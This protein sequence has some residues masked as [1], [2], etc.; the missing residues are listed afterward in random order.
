MTRRLPAAFAIGVRRPVHAGD[1]RPRERTTWRCELHD[2]ADPSLL[3]RRAAD[4]ADARSAASASRP[5]YT[6]DPDAAGR[7]D[8]RAGGCARPLALGTVR[9]A[10]AARHRRA[11]AASIPTSRRSRAT[12][13]SP[14]IAACRRS[15]SRP[16]S[17]AAQGTDFKQLSEYRVGDSVRHIDW[18]AT[19]RHGQADRPRVPGRARPVRH[20]ARRLRPAHARRRSAGRDRHDALRPGAERRDAAVVRRAQAGRRGRRDDVRHASRRGALVRAAQGR[21]GAERADGRSCTASSRRRRIP[22]TSPRRR[23][24]CADSASARWSSSSPTSA[25]R[26]AP[27][28]A[29][30]CACCA[31][32]ISCCSRACASGSSA[33]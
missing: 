25:T 12:P 20:A 26:T 23:I 17:S 22:T 3:D 6:V 8:V 29:R 10:R 7:G 4:R 31:R 16:T 9:A 13:G 1:R 2:H 14:A 19:L 32:A 33:S 5:T 15:A 28:W 30:R 11:C 21:A 18:R 24:C 27:S